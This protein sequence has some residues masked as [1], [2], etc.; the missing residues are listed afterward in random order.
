MSVSN[1]KKKK[2]MHF[3]PH[4]VSLDLQRSLGSLTALGGGL[5]AT[6][7][8]TSNSGGL[9]DLFS[10]LRERVMRKPN[11]ELGCIHLCQPI[12]STV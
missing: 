4:L 6:G 10:G 5:G 12:T 11:L 1:E 9:S 7:L 3:K 8:T 2:R